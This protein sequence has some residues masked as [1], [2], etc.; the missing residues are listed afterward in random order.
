MTGLRIT[1]GV[2]GAA[3]LAAGLL[4]SRPAV[5]A[6][7]FILGAVGFVIAFGC[8]AADL[9]PLRP[10]YAATSGLALVDAVL[11]A[12][13]GQISR[14]LALIAALVLVLLS[15]APRLIRARRMNRAHTGP[16]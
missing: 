12:I 1:Y 14:T 8:L 2:L 4:I 16:P 3:G 10:V 6:P 15:A 13:A 7:L 11:M 9:L 5:L